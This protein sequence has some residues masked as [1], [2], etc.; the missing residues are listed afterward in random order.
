VLTGREKKESNASGLCLLMKSRAGG[1]HSK[2]SNIIERF[3]TRETQTA[4]AYIIFIHD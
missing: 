4:R 1:Y 3:T 2:F